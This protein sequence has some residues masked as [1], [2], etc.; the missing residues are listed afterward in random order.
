MCSSRTILR[1]LTGGARPLGLQSLHTLR[2]LN[3]RLKGFVRRHAPSLIAF[4]L[5]HFSNTI[6]APRSEQSA[7][8]SKLACWLP[9]IILCRE[10]HLARSIAYVSHLRSVASLQAKSNW[11]S[12]Q[13]GRRKSVYLSLRFERWHL[14]T[15]FT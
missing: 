12:V 10:M 6:E 11:D 14:V 13:G 9:Q 8:P 2:N 4:E 3:I 1:L 15:I 7:S 5:N